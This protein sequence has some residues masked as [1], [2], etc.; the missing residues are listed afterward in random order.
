MPS[1]GRNCFSLLRLKLISR[2]PL[3]LGSNIV[4]FHL[5]W[6]NLILDVILI[7][8]LFLF[9]KVI[10]SKI[11]I[12]FILYIHKYIFLRIDYD[13][14][15]SFHFDRAVLSIF[16]FSAFSQK[17]KTY[18]MGLDVCV[19][20]SEWESEWVSVFVWMRVWL[21]EWLRERERERERERISEHVCA[22]KALPKY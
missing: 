2:S 15:W 22:G 17:N 13:R 10:S 18:K 7:C 20:V 11:L 16:A 8:V 6:Q 9:I 5:G 12:S 3:W 19:C 21:S 1:R 14:H 4:A